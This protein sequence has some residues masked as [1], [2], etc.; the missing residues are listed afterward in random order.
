MS[1]TIIATKFD[2]GFV[3]MTAGA[4]EEVS[5]EERFECLQRH[6]DGDWGDLC[7]ADWRINDAALKVGGR[8]VSRYRTKNGTAFYIITEADR[9][10]EGLEHVE[11][12]RPDVILTDIA[13]PEEDG[14]S[15]LRKL[16][17]IEQKY[18]WHLPVV[19]LTAFAGAEDRNRIMA[20]GFSA[21]LSK[22]IDASMLVQVVDKYSGKN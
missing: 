3:V 22:P 8:L 17:A 6:L 13:M 16:R 19:A 7:E 4:H 15:F 9:S 10:M 11:T 14:F 5:E 2:P 20:A 21:H 18:N 1:M 12:V